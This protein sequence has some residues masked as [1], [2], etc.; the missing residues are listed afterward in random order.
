[1]FGDTMSDPITRAVEL[2]LS[3]FLHSVPPI[4]ESESCLFRHFPGFLWSERSRDR[5]SWAWDY[6]FDIQRDTERR[7][8][9]RP[10]IQNR[11]SR[12]KSFVTTGL[13]NAFDHLYRDHQIS[14]PKGKPKSELQQRD[15][16]KG[17]KKT[18]HSVADMFKLDPN[19]ADEQALANRII[20]GFDPGHF[21][22][23]AYE[24]LLHHLETFKAIA[25]DFPDPTHFKI[26]VNMA[27]KKLNEYYVKLDETPVF[28]ASLALC[29]AYRWDWFESR[30]EHRIE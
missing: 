18:H 14:A 23:Q 8:V 12:P 3:P 16:R 24:Y 19:K 11:N 26:G 17:Q 22:R 10:C 27:W 4:I 21:Q 1:M 15:E 2:P 30:W 28:Y 13:Q 7:W 25:D 29:P 20:K 9:C 6:G 5:R